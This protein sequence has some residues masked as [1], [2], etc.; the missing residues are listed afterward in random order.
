MIHKLTEPEKAASLFAGW[1]ETVIW[2]C[3]QKIMGEIY[4]DEIQNP[5]SAAAVLVISFSW[6]AIRRKSLHV[7]SPAKRRAGFSFLK[8]RN[9]KK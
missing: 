3:L 7:F 6:Q 1:E 5:Q 2:S 8:I 4:A 9:G